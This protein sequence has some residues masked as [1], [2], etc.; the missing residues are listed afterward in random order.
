MTMPPQNPWTSPPPPGP[1]TGPASVSGVMR[2]PRT[3]AAYIAQ[4]RK[5][6][7]Y[8]GRSSELFVIHITNILLVIVTLGIHRFWGRVRVRRYVWAN[9]AFAGQRF[10]Y[11]GTGGELF[12]G[13]LLATLV[14]VPILAAFFFVELFTLGLHPAIGIGQRVLQAVVILTLVYAGTFAARRYQMSR[15]LWSG[16]RFRQ[17]GSPWAYAAMAVGGLVLTLL[18]LG[19]YQP[20]LA[21]RL[22]RMEIG[23]L[24]IGTLPF[25]FEGQGRDLLGPFTL[26]WALTLPTLGFVWFWYFGRRMR[27]IA[28]KTTLGGIRFAMPEVSG[29]EL[30]WLLAGNFLLMVLTLG[31]LYPVAV[32]RTMAFWASHLVAEGTLDPNQIQQIAAEAGAGEGLAGFFGLDSLAA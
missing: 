23:G 3:G 30:F 25:R 1:Q 6:L 20:Y 31:L 28:E 13:F 9:T 21:M 8:D 22:K 18:T 16:I 32:N 11:T 7:S 2:D 15:S 19:F 27:Y 4:G 14:M 29:F 24:Q 26:A 12:K 17:T 10:E 5:P